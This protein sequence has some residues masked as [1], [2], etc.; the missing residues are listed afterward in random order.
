MIGKAV[1][2]VVFLGLLGGGAFYSVKMVS[3]DAGESLGMAFGKETDTTIQ[4]HIAVPIGMPTADPPELNANFKPDWPK[5]IADH[6]DITD[7]AGNTI[8][9]RRNINSTII[10]DNDVRFIPDSY[11][12]GDLTQGTKYTLTL[13]PI[14]S[15]PEVYK[16]EMVAPAEAQPF[17]RKLFKPAY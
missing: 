10:S 17:S 11:L 1:G 14:V 2:W 13:T 8:T 9:L 3:Q 15:E 6:F 16:Y 7:N 5:W 12:I 4:V